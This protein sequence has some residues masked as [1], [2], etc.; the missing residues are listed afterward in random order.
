MPF[1][2]NFH[3]QI[4]QLKRD[5]LLPVSTAFKRDSF[6]VHIRKNWFLASNCDLKIYSLSLTLENNYIIEL[7]SIFW[8]TFCKS[9]PI[10]KCLEIVNANE[11]L[12]DA[13]INNIGYPVISG[14]MFAFFTNEINTESLLIFFERINR[15][16]AWQDM[17]VFLSSS[18]WNLS[19]LKCSSR[20]ICFSKTV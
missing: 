6:R 4:L 3:V 5:R 13:I 9:T 8:F 1:S 14:L 17:Y 19:A 10:L 2:Q 12:I 16:N 20:V 7:K 15:S 18:R 11:S